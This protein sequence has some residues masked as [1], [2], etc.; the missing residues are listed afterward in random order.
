MYENS[1]EKLKWGE[2][3][4]YLFFLLM[5][6]ATSLGLNSGHRAYQFIFMLSLFLV[7]AKIALTEYTKWEYI[8][9]LL[10]CI[11]FGSAFLVNGEK[12]LLLTVLAIIGCKGI[13][14]WKLLK[15]VLLCRVSVMG[16][17]VVLAWLEII[18]NISHNLPKAGK[19]Y[20]IYS[21][22]YVHPNSFY[23]NLLV[24]A[25][26]L[27]VLVYRSMRFYQI[28]VLTGIMYGAYK[29]TMCRTGWMLWLLMIVILLCNKLLDKL[30]YRN[31]LYRLFPWL[32]PGLAALSF[33]CIL[34]YRMGASPA[35]VLDGILTGRIRLMTEAFFAA[36]FHLL[37][38]A[39]GTSLS[40]MDNCYVNLY[41]RYGIL[42]FLLI[43]VAAVK[44]FQRLLKEEN[45]AVILG[46]GVLAVY[47]FMEQ[48]PLNVAWNPLLLYAGCLLFASENQIAA[49]GDLK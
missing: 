33:V 42:I 23:A 49:K 8:R 2:I 4:F 35:Y 7:L 21:Y 29:L 39:K 28:A 43:M 20:L 48:F 18:P 31:Q 32:V 10:L 16:I 6:T 34:L 47:G 44:L 22:G 41:V 40:M 24:I 25:V 26:L 27:V 46:L 37:G 36:P 17:T 3:L 9:I 45:Y 11:L 13:D 1:Y 12:T 15:A 19:R 5:N 38:V 14:L 30:G